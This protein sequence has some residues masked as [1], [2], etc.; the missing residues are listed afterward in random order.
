MQDRLEQLLAVKVSDL[1]H[2]VLLSRLED[3]AQGNLL[4]LQLSHDFA[5]SVDNRGHSVG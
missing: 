2:A 3:L 4:L 5:H 1:R